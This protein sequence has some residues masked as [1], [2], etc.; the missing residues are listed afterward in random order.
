M[1]ADR[2]LKRGFARE[3][4]DKRKD[5]KKIIWCPPLRKKN[6]KKKH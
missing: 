6:S 5:E 2:N 3:R 4:R 1:I